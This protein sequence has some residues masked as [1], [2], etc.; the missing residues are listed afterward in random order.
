VYSVAGYVRGPFCAGSTTLPATFTLRAM[1]SA[2]GT[3]MGATIVDPCPWSPDQPMLYHAEIKATLGN[4]EVRLHRGKL[5]IRRLSPR[6]KSLFLN[7][8]RWVMRG[9]FDYGPAADV[10]TWRQYASVRVVRRS[11][12]AVFHAAA[13]L[14][15]MV[16]D[17]VSSRS[18]DL[19]REIRLMIEEPA[20]VMALLQ[21]GASPP[22]DVAS[23]AP[24]LLLA[25][26]VSTAAEVQP[27]AHA[28][29]I[30]LED[31]PDFAL[32]AS[33]IN[34]PI[35]VERRY[36]GTSLAEARAAIDTLQADLAPI[37]QFAGYVV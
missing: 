33:S 26:R 9:I 7:G 15:L 3:M 32:H 35:I 1:E 20:I 4:G 8:K 21:P 10:A 27:W 5:A 2:Q 36:C 6:G 29:W 23:T 25:Q 16:V 12:S 31:M 30:K 22:D 37:G 34:I 13:E 14:G 28:A 24:N 18:A 19:G 17:D 11:N